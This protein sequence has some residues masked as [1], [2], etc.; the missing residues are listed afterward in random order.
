MKNYF[1]IIIDS[2]VVAR[3]NTEGSHVPLV[4][5]LLMVTPCKTIA[6]Y[7]HP[8]TDIDAVKYGTFPTSQGYLMAMSFCSYFAPAP[9]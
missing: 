3:N 1:E 9:M 5:F 4:Q 7:H 8:H 6:Q 2:H